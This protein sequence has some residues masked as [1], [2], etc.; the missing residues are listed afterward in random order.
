M[1]ATKKKGVSE[2][3]RLVIAPL[4]VAAAIAF[5]ASPAVA[6]GGAAANCGPPGQTISEFAKAPGSVPD[7]F[8]GTGIPGQ[9]V[10]EECAPGQ[11]KNP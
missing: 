5:T 9:E 10:K 11:Q 7:V 1:S 8:F 2:M 4:T 6:A 3:R